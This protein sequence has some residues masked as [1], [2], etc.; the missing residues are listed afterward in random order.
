MPKAMKS[1]EEEMENKGSLKSGIK[2]LKEWPTGLSE[3][4]LRVS[5]SLDLDTVLREV[6]AGTCALTGAGIGGITTGDESGQMLDFV[7]HGLSPDAR[8]QLLDLP[9]EAELWALIEITRAGVVVIDVRSGTLQSI[10][11]E[12]RRMVGDHCAPGRPAG[13]LLKAFS[14]HRS[15]GSEIAPDE[16]PLARMLDE[17]GM[18]RV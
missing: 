12:S 3:V 7:T 1:Y 2:A 4:S 10:N 18:I 11:R 5:E 13:E 9:R 14:V 17:P 6:V 16:N 15:D 8:R